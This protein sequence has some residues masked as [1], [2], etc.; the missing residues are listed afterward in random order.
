M[1]AIA[2]GLNLQQKLDRLVAQIRILGLEPSQQLALAVTWA[3][4]TWAAKTWAA[5]RRICPHLKSWSLGFGPDGPET[6][7]FWPVF[8]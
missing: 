1:I 8:R 4:K 3:A 7:F 2:H 6:H 5:K